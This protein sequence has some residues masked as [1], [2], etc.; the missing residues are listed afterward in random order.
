M[1]VLPTRQA[2]FVRVWN[3][4]KWSAVSLQQP[5]STTPACAVALLYLLLLKDG[6]S[7]C[8]LLHSAPSSL[9][10]IAVGLLRFACPAGHGLAPLPVAAVRPAVPS[11]ASPSLFASPTS[12]PLRCSAQGLRQT[13][14]TTPIPWLRRC[15]APL[16]HFIPALSSLTFRPCSARRASSMFMC[17]TRWPPV[18]CALPKYL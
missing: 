12:I 17:A 5:A 9:H 13:P 7:H 1:S 4:V 11:T 6:Q 10:F 18:G 14:T 8:T 2:L 15:F 16:L 3:L